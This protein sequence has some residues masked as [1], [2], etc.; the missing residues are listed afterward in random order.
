MKSMKILII[1][2]DV[3]LAGYIVK[4]L[5]EE[6]HQALAVHDGEEGLFL[7]QENDF[8]A[9]VLDRML[10]KRDGMAVLAELRLQARMTPVLMLTAMGETDQRVEGLR[11]GADDYLAKPFALAELLARLEALARRA[12]QEP[13]QTRYESGD[14]T[15]DLLSRQARRAG[16]LLPLKPKEFDLL[17]FFMRHPGRVVTR[18]ML[19]EQIWGY[20]FDPQTN[21]I[22][23]HVSRLRAH[24]DGTGQ[25]IET[26]RGAGYRFHG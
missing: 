26:V 24:I 11:Q 10:P 21:V 7:A 23:V 6:G 2:D 16:K 9:I 3:G 20:H 13:P 8:D 19:L 1:E 14:L 5:M 12:A 22:D 4:A 18:S 15:L 17:A 25:R